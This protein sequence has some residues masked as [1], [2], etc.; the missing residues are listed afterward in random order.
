MRSKDLKEERVRSLEQWAERL[1]RIAAE[2]AYGPDGP[3]LDVNLTQMEDLVV[4]LQRAFCK[5]MCEE[6]TARQA[7][8]LA[9][10]VPCPE[11]GSE[12]SVEQPG[13]DEGSGGVR[14]RSIQT[15][16]GPF[17]LAE[18]RAYCRHCRRSFFPSAGGVGD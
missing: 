6:A 16:G 5:G 18:P 4:Q 17:D 3:G 12:C 14:S 7:G 10:T 15:R 1:G 9:A 13:G 11:C 8:R 2:E